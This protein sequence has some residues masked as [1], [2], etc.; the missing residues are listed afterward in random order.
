MLTVSNLYK[1]ID[2][3]EILR[4]VDF[5]I[6]PGHVVGLIGRNG[7]GKTTL[8]K[9]M[10]GI[11]DPDM[12]EVLYDGQSI[13]QTPEVKQDVVF[14]PDMPEAWF[15]YTPL[16]SARLF[17]LVYPK[18]EWDQFHDRMK[19][20]GLPLNRRIRHMSKGM[21]MM[22]ST[23]LGISTR[24]NFILL[25]EPTNGVDPIAKKQVLGLL[26]EAA[27]AGITLVISSHLLE[28]LE[29][30]TDVLLIMKDGCVETHTTEL[31][32]TNQLRKLQVAFSS[33]A[34]EDLLQSDSIHV[35]EHVG[36]VYTLLV[37]NR[38]DN[39]TVKQLEQAE[40][41][42][43]EPLP[44]KLEDLYIWKLGGRQDVE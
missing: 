31:A 25:D 2:D 33:E 41:L 4:G 20:F 18:F 12:G 42:F 19:E 27:E 37:D 26:M 40:P 34:P 35:L 3:K 14:V 44:V 32:M 15:G 11:L 9:T 5:H 16:E 22:F 39:E 17:A 1:S 21:R 28:E 24:A 23:V 7:A 29:R 43:I 30:M 38:A 13:H 6:E 8:L 10:A 36:R